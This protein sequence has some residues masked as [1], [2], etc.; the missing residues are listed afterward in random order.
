MRKVFLIF[1]SI[2]FVGSFFLLSVISVSAESK[3]IT[4]LNKTANKETGVGYDIEKV[5]NPMEYIAKLI[6]QAL[7]PMFIGV[8][9]LIIMIIAGF[10]WMT[11]QGNEQQVGKAKNIIIYA[12]IG[13]AVVLAAYI[14]V[15]IILP[16][17]QSVI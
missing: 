13:L 10:M 8:S 7:T 2:C 16:I 1:L 14:I 9:F 4:G 3:F 15:K 11:A 6:G 12:I 17:W 5:T